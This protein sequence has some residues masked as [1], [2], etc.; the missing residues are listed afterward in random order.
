MEVFARHPDIEIIDQQ[1]GYWN[2]DKART[3]AEALL[4]KHPQID[5]IWAQDD[6]MAEGVEQAAREAGRLDDLFIFGGAGKEGD[7]QARDGGRPDVPR[8]D[9][10]P[11]GHDLRRRRP[12][13]RPT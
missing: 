11:A 7:R 2:R 12:W 3:A 10:L 1:P 13:P 5:A 6:D 8:D 9:H 4:Q